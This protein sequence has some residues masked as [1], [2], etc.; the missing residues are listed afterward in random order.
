MN[1]FWFYIS[2][3]LSGDWLQIFPQEVLA[4]FIAKRERDTHHLILKMSVNRE[5]MNF[6]LALWL[7]KERSGFY[8]LYTK[9][10]L[11]L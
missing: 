2:G 9:Y 6:G 3:N 1:D 11:F 8:Y 7:I 5:A 10:W 4:L